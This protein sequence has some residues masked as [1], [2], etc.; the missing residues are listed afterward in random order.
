MGNVF[1]VLCWRSVARQFQVNGKKW[2]NTLG[3]LAVNSVEHG[4]QHGWD[5][6]SSVHFTVQK[7]RRVMILDYELIELISKFWYCV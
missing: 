4:C 1:P 7:E 2:S 3:G 5:D 6:N